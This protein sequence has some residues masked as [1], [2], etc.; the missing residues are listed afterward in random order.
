M[1][2]IMTQRAGSLECL[3][4]IKGV[5]VPSIGMETP[6]HANAGPWESFNVGGGLLAPCERSDTT[7]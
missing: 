2:I 5:E 7:G 4:N 3:V 6:P 1:M